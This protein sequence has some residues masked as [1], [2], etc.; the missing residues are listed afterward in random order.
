M[1]N[2]TVH[3]DMA[4]PVSRVLLGCQKHCKAMSVLHYLTGLQ[5][6]RFRQ[7]YLCKS[8]SS[9]FIKQISFS[10]Q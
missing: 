5:L 6:S 2:K 3:L 9:N 8:P 7:L 10:L 4:A 1:Q